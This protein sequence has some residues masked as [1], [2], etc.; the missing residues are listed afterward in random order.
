LPDYFEHLKQ[1][2]NSLIARIY[3]VFT[4]KME[5]I[6]PV[7]LLLMANTIRCKS[8]NSI[9]NVFD[10]KGSMVNREVKITSKTKNTSTLK[11]LNLQMIKR[12]NQTIGNDFIKFSKAD[13]VHLNQQIEKDI[14]M[15]MKY[16]LM[17]Y[18]LLF[19]VEINDDQLQKAPDGPEQDEERDDNPSNTEVSNKR[20]KFVSCCGNFTYHM[21]IIDY[22]QEFNW[23]KW[24]ESK[25]KT[26]VLRR[27]EKLISAVRPEL[28]AQRFCKF[29][30]EELLLDSILDL[31]YEDIGN[32]QAFK[33][34]Y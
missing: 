26:A 10:L 4:V 9:M 32:E 29:M 33:S 6:V 2:P 24:G 20:H 1:N 23:E 7:H 22:L 14:C 27:N 18:S 19:A 13:I 12:K 8:G 31:W 16:N 28:Y 30:K 5:D 11:D 15:L 25:F 34:I 3:G 21:A 17:D